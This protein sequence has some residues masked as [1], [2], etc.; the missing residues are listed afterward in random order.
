MQFFGR[1]FFYLT[2]FRCA[3]FIGA[4]VLFLM[5]APV[6]LCFGTMFYD[7]PVQFLNTA[8]CGFC[9]GKVFYDASVQKSCEA[10]VCYSN[11]THRV[12]VYGAHGVRCANFLC[13]PVLSLV[14]CISD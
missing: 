12:G 14:E 2:L 13:A 11:T 5:N 3:W 4:P 9:F 6:G 10:P 1:N 8:L 7:A